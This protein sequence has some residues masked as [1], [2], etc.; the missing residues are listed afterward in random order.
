MGK[1]C[2]QAV[3]A[4]REEAGVVGVV[5]VELA[6]PTVSR[7]PRAVGA[8]SCTDTPIADV[9]EAGGLSSEKCR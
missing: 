8:T 3:E 7:A 4:V 9:P 5:G 2:L 1:R 6:N